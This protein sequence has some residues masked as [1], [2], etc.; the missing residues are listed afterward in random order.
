MNILKTLFG[1]KGKTEQTESTKCALSVTTALEAHPETIPPFDLF[2]DN[3]APQPE[4]TITEET[5]NR[6]T[7]FLNRNYRSMGNNDGY[8]YH[9]QETLEIGKKKIRAEFQLIIDQSIQEKLASRLKMKNL[10][11]DV[12]RVSVE[13]RQKLENTVYELNASLALLQ[14]QKEFSA[15]SEGW[16]MNAIHSY[17][18]GFVQGINDYIAGETLLISIKNI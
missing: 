6:V 15:E 13:T 18:Q 16:V 7:V 14:K 5:Q 1:N 3:K 9:S 12:T 11:V 2:I 17:H 10:I 8:E 4:L